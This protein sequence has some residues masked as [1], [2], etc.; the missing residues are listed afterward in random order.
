MGNYQRKVMC[1]PKYLSD[2]EIEKIHEQSVAILQNTGIEVNHAEA[3]KMLDKA[4][5][6]V[7]FQTQ[8]VKI[9]PK[10]VTRCLDTLPEKCI[11]A[12]RN[13]EK[14]CILEPGG[15]SYSRNGGGSDLYP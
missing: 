7:D 13:P 3:L 1:C 6:R 12:A 4:G 2:S 14:D 10:L 11:L 15:R 8:K 5:A 9:P